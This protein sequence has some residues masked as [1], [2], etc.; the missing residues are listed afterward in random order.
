MKNENISII[1]GII[2]LILAII[3]LLQKEFKFFDYPFCEY[4]LA[5]SCLYNKRVS[6]LWKAN[7]AIATG[8]IFWAY[9]NYL[10]D[11]IVL[12]RSNNSINYF[13]IYLAQMT[14]IVIKDSFHNVF[15]YKRKAETLFKK[16]LDDIEYLNLI[17]LIERKRLITRCLVPA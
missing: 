12:L 14:G 6:L 5:H 1:I 16:F 11:V 8:L 17:I 2:S 9:F 10:R 3:P 7:W 4:D 13:A 15:A